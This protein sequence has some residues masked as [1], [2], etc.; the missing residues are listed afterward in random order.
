MDQAHVH[1][2]P[3]PSGPP[4]QVTTGH[5]AEFPVLCGVFSL[6]IY[7]ILS[8]SSV[9]VSI[10][11]SQFLPPTPCFPLGILTFVFYVCMNFKV[12]KG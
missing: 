12:R 9:Y 3:F 4:I 7:F 2:Y 11:I 6:V 10:L 8:V 1:L 5:Y